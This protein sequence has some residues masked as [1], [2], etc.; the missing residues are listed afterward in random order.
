VLGA[1]GFEVLRRQVLRESAAEAEVE[2]P[3]APPPPSA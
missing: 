3:A 1:V 2:A